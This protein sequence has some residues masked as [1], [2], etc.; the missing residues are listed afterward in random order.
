[1]QKHVKARAWSTPGT[2]WFACWWL[3]VMLITTACVPPGSSTAGQPS[4]PLPPATYSLAANRWRLVEIRYRGSTL[5]F[6]ALQPVHVVF[7]LEGNLGITTTNCN[8]GGYRIFFKSRY[9]YILTDGA[10]TAMNCGELAD[11]QYTRLIEAVKATTAYQMQDD[12]VLLTGDDVRIVLALDQPFPL[13]PGVNPTLLLNQWRLVE[14]T[15][16]DKPVAFTDLQPVLLAFHITG[17]L[18]IYP[19]DCIDGAYRINAESERRYRLTRVEFTDEKCRNN[20]EAQFEQV[21]AALETTTEYALQDNQ[22]ILT[23]EDVRIVLEIDNAP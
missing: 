5:Q 7:G 3:A 13:I 23:G 17:V 2:Q 18:G 9:H 19:T 11:A 8:G 4:S 20:G 21:T 16:S 1:M 12:Q 22:L 15:Q 10:T 14:V 6:D